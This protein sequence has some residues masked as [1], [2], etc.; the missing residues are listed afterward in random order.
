VYK[1]LNLSIPAH[2]L[3]PTIPEPAQTNSAGTS[4]VQSAMQ[5][6]AWDEVGNSEETMKHGINDAY[7]RRHLYRAG[8]P[9]LT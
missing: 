1:P 8:K 2:G 6:A 9:A 3:F 7:L 5:L 4:A